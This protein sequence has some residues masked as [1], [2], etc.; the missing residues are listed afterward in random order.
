ME[1]LWKGPVWGQSGFE[2]LTRGIVL[3]L[4][5]LGVKIQLDDKLDWNKERCKL[6]NE[7]E[8]RLSRMVEYRAAN[9]VAYIFHQFPSN[10]D[11]RLAYSR[12]VSI[13][14]VC[15]TL[16]ETDKCPMPWIDRLNKMDEVWTFSKFNRETFTSSGVN[17]V[18]VMPVGVDTEL[19]SLNVIPL[20]IKGK[21]GFTFITNGDFTERK[22]FEGLLEAFVKE[23]TYSDDVCLVVKAHFGGFVKSH[24]DEVLRRLREI[25][26]R[27]NSKNPPKVL[28]MGDKVPEEDMPRFYAVG[29]CFALVSRGEGLGLPYLEAMACGKPCIAANWGGHTQY[30]NNENSFLVGAEVKVID[31]MEYIKKCLYALNHKWAH[32]HLDEVRDRMRFVVTCPELAKEKGKKAREDM[33][34][35]TWQKSALW[36]LSR[37][38]GE[39]KE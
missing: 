15:Y 1:I 4:D 22:N 34:K 17:N 31:D 19:F 36:V 16:F 7:E 18:K 23:F 12:G 6:E 38:F 29:D 27:F 37:I 35:L 3:A 30:L 20:N 24:R 21:R 9:P 33:E 25:V 5:K 39:G 10:E 2:K 13:L 11:I 14:K 26:Y 8:F 32:P 28:F